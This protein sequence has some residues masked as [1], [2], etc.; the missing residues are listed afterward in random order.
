MLVKERAKMLIRHK[1]KKIKEVEE[2]QA[3][4]E[5]QKSASYATELRIH[6]KKVFYFFVSQSAYSSIC[7]VI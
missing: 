6:V 5:L 3:P 4:N 7:P 1:T 2:G